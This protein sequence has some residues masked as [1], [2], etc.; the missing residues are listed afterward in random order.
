MKG[1][2]SFI[3]FNSFF[4]LKTKKKT[5]SEKKVLKKII[6]CWMKLK[7]NCNFTCFLARAVSLKCLNNRVASKKTNVRIQ[8]NETKKELTIIMSIRI[9]SI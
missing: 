9:V 7:K 2:I 4:I 1:H 5:L 8:K 6:S 3:K